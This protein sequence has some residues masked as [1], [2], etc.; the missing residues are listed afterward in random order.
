[1]ETEDRISLLSVNKPAAKGARIVISGDF[2][3]KPLPRRAFMRGSLLA[4]AALWVGPAFY[5]LLAK[6]VP[7][8]LGLAETVPA[9]ASPAAVV[10]VAAVIPAGMQ[11][12]GIAVP[13]LTGLGKKLYKDKLG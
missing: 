4:L 9:V 12:R 1:M 10:P 8:A 6:D 7:L 3:H 13:S 5:R 2:L 11:L